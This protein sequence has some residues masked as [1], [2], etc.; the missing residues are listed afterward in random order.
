MEIRFFNVVIQ[1]TKTWQ[2]TISCAHMH[3]SRVSVTFNIRCPPSPILQRPCRTRVT[4]LDTGS[5]TVRGA[6]LC[7]TLD[8]S[9][10]T[11][12]ESLTHWI[13]PSP[14]PT[15]CPHPHAHGPP[16]SHSSFLKLTYSS[17]RV[18][19]GARASQVGSPKQ[20]RLPTT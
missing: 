15:N 2:S 12:H 16:R 9:P 11:R 18:L 13:Y 4:Y 5:R 3:R 17:Q 8:S 6:I 7:C 14:V 19:I 1:T 10:L 20:Q